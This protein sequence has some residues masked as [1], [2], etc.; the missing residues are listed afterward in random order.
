M[1][2]PQIAMMGL[3]GF[4]QMKPEDQQGLLKLGMQGMIGQII[5]WGLVILV[6]VVIVGTIVYSVYS[7]LGIGGLVGLVTGEGT[8]LQ[9]PSGMEETTG[10]LCYTKCPAGMTPGD[11]VP[12][13]CYAN[14]PSGWSGGETLAHIQKGRRPSQPGSTRTKQQ[15]NTAAGEVNHLGL[16]YKLPQDGQSWYVTSPG[17]I[18]LR[19]PPGSNDS[20]TTCWY[21]RGVGRTPDLRPCAPGLRDDGTSCWSDAHIFGRVRAAGWNGTCNSDEEKKCEGVCGASLVSCYKICPPGY[22][23]DGLTC[24]KTD[25]GIKTTKFDRQYC[26][27]DEDLIDGLCYKKPR[28]GFKCDVTHCSVSKQVQAVTGTVPQACEAGYAPG[29]G[30]LSTFCYPICPSGYERVEGDVE[31]CLEICPNGWQ[32]IGVGGCVKPTHE[33][34]VGKPLLEVGVCPP[35]KKKVGPACMPDD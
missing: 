15:C 8:P 23:N 18:G 3:Q 27:A 10:G 6:V 2:A 32:D 24:R 26:A 16:C 35:G 30:G 20:G 22:A 28:P 12:T 7:G 29:P 5:L 19:C 4:Q 21:D 25:I 31:A 11:G 9:C 14:K 34:G 17:F 33:R 13:M 1:A